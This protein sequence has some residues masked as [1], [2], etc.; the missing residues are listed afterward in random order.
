MPLIR[1]AVTKGTALEIKKALVDGVHQA[2]Y[3]EP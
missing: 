2:L 1:S 3:A